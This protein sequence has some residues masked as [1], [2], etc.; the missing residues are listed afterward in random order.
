M[1]RIIIFFIIL[2]LIYTGCIIGISII[3]NNY[4][5]GYRDT[6]D[7]GEKDDSVDERPRYIKRWNTALFIIG[8]LSLGYMFQLLVMFD[9][10]YEIKL[11]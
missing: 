1:K 4:T 3:K 9:A 6:D 8:L 7:D 10:E 11:K 2:L 5:V